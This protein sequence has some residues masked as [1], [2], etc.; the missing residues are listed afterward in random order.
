MLRKTEHSIARNWVLVKPACEDVLEPQELNL[1]ACTKGRSANQMRNV[2]QVQSHDGW[3]RARMLARVCP[4][5]VATRGFILVCP[6]ARS[7]KFTV[8]LLRSPRSLEI[9]HL[10]SFLRAFPRD[11]GIHLSPRFWAW[12]AQP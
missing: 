8:P 10:V 5:S 6:S 1:E 7:E 11:L 4:L 2:A 3:R 12:R 9:L